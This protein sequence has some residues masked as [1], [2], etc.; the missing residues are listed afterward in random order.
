MTFDSIHSDIE[1]NCIEGAVEDSSSAFLRTIDG[2]VP[3]ERDFL[4]HWER[5]QRQGKELPKG[6]CDEL[7]GWKGVSV[8]KIDGYDEDEISKTIKNRLLYLP[9]GKKKSICRFRLDAGAGV[10]KHTPNESHGSHH[11]LY[12]CDDFDMNKIVDVLVSKVDL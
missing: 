4:S 3:K 11:D 9:Q 7:C 5:Y 10:V 8:N 12:K 2:N 1:C 6:E